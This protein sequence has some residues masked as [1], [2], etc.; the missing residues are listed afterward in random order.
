MANQSMLHP[1]Q[2][3]ACS[4]SSNRPTGIYS[5]CSAHPIVLEAAVRQAVED[6]TVLLVEAT[7]NQVNQFGGYTGMR[8]ADFRKFV[9]QI[10]ARLGLAEKDLILGGDHL[11]PNPWRNLPAEEACNMLKIL[12][13]NIRGLDL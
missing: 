1:L 7:S 9:C 6:R 3:L 10:A 8:P 11:G 12:W 5:V 4:I 2:R 13:P